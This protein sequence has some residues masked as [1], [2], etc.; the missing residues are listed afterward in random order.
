MQDRHSLGGQ[1]ERPRVVVIGR[2]MF[3][4]LVR[5][6]LA[7]YEID[8]V[9]AEPGTPFDRAV[10]EADARFLIVGNGNGSFDDRLGSACTEL[11]ETH[12]EVRALAVLDHGRRGVCSRCSTTSRPRCWHRR[13]GLDRAASSDG[14]PGRRRDRFDA[15]GCCSAVSRGW[16]RA[17]RHPTQLRAPRVECGPEPG[18]RA[19]AQRPSRRSPR[20]PAP[21]L[22]RALDEVGQR[23]GR[24]GARADARGPPLPHLRLERG[25]RPIGRGPAPSTS[26]C[27]TSWPCS[28]TR[29]SWCRARSFLA[30]RPPDEL[31]AAA[32]GR[33]A[34]RHPASGRGLSQARRVLGNDG[35]RPP[36]EAM[37]VRV[38]RDLAQ[39]FAACR[40][41]PAAS[42]RHSSRR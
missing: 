35:R 4:D 20:E 27:G 31:P 38:D 15:G 22:E 39:G 3:C 23:Q 33:A 28:R 29:R 32:G 17:R 24:G 1:M 34:A 12:P 30:G 16:A 6:L 41:G 42:P 7:E 21:A 36:V 5:L 26:C 10:E 8:V 18:Q 19:G 37:R 14:Q 9:G 40:A 11:L 25:H 13:S 2:H